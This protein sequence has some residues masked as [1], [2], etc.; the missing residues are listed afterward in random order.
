MKIFFE[1]KAVGQIR[2]FE[3]IDEEFIKR[4][5]FSNI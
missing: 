5:V 2:S 1:H 4:A 3:Q